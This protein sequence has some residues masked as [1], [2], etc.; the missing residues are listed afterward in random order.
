MSFH[1]VLYNSIFDS[2]SNTIISSAFEPQTPV[3][4]F[5][6]LLAGLTSFMDFSKAKLKNAVDNASFVLIHA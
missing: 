1:T 2:P 6:G 3:L 5:T 4:P